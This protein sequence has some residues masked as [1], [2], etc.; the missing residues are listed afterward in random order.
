MNS[1]IASALGALVVL[2]IIGAFYA[3]GCISIV[4]RHE[5]GFVYDEWNGKI[6][7][8]DCRGWIMRPWPKYSTYTK[9]CRPYQVQVTADTHIGKRVL[10]AK[11]VR[12]NPKGIETFI[13]WH[14]KDAGTT[15][16]ELLEILKC[17]AFAP[18]GGKSCPFIEVLNETSPL[19]QTPETAK[20]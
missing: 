18:D 5:F 17:Y 10:N 1:K 13:A 8:N 14:S 9:D 16:S 3:I 2:T 15:T 11:L 7:E 4:D 19:A 6:V 12:F 20:Q